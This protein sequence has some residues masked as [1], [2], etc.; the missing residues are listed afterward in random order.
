MKKLWNSSILALVL[1]SVLALSATAAPPTTD[2]G[3]V[4]PFPGPTGRIPS[5]DASATLKRHTDKAH[6]KIETGNLVAGDAYTVWAVTWNDPGECGGDGCGEADVCAIPG[7][8]V[9]W[10]T[11]KVIN[12]N[13][14]ATFNG[15]VHEGAVGGDQGKKWACAYDTP[16]LFD[17]ENAEIHFV[18]RSHGQPIPGMVDDQI[19]TLNGGCEGGVPNVC[20]DHQAALFIP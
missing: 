13:G 4:V 19:S 11:G 9:Y 5:D 6:V 1:L 16:G 15:M 7:S 20:E 8:S 18:I 14:T 2:D 12:S 10:V 17:A 3:L